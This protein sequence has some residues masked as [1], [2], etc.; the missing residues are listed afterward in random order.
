MNNSRYLNLGCGNRFL[1]DWINVDFV[2]YDHNVISH[3]LLKKLPFSD[4]SFDVLYSSH[5]LEHFS[6]KDA[7][8]FLQECYRVTNRN[9]IIR[10]V[11]PDME[12]I[13]NSYLKSLNNVLSLSNLDNQFRYQCDQIELLDQLTRTYSGGMLGELWSQDDLIDEDY[14]LQKGGDEFVKYRQCLKN[15]KVDSLKNSI[16]RT[17][18]NFSLFILEKIIGNYNY[19]IWKEVQFRKTGEIHRWMYDRYSL[20]KVLEES[21]FVEITQFDAFNSQIDN[22]GEFQ[23]LDV[24]GGRIRKPDSLIMEARKR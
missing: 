23:Y 14:L 9:G 8:F 11:V 4:N 19:K 1:K 15:N 3:N 21:G 13:V 7:I 5:V 18:Y 12:L 10:I 6:Y 17:L 24:E 22:W 2:S 16:K 20:K